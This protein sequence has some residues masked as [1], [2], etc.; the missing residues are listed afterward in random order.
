MYSSCRGGGGGETFADETRG[1]KRKLMYWK[2]M[3]QSA[4]VRVR[5]AGGR[6]GN[7]PEEK[8][9]CYSGVLEFSVAEHEGGN[10]RVV[11]GVVVCEKKGKRERERKNEKVCYKSPTVRYLPTRTFKKKKKTSLSPST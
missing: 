9:A 10:D 1:N 2:R 7:F 6:R 5:W 4:T 8:R 11:G 3:E